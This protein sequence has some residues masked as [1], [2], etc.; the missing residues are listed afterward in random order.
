MRIFT[1]FKLKPGVEPETY[2]EWARTEDV[3]AC[4]AKPACQAM[5]VYMIDGGST[6]D[7]P[8]VIEII[9]ATSVEEWEAATSAPD[10]AD[11]M[12]RWNELADAD[13]VVSLY[14]HSN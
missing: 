4:L 8:G 1:T 7:R 2:A 9:E 6:D 13:T 10:H 3:P 11:L 12:K 14:S 5:E